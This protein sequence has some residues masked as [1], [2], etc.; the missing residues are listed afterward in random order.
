M[1]SLTLA[2]PVCS[3]GRVWKEEKGVSA[4]DDDGDQGIAAWLAY[5]H[6]FPLSAPTTTTST[7][8]IGLVVLSTSLSTVLSFFPNL[9]P[10]L[11]SRARTTST[12]TKKSA[13]DLSVQDEFGRISS[14]G[15]ARQAVQQHLV[16]AK[17]A[18]K[19]DGKGTA[20]GRSSTGD[21]DQQE[22]VPP[23]ATFLPLSL[24][25]RGTNPTTSRGRN[26]ILPTTMGIFRTV[27]MS[28]W[29]SKSGE[30]ADTDIPEHLHE[31]VVGA[32][33]QWRRRIVRGTKPSYSNCRTQATPSTP[34]PVAFE[35]YASGPK[36]TLSTEA[37]QDRE[38]AIREALA[39]LAKLGFAGLTETDLGKLNKADEYEEELQLMA[40]VRAYFQVAYKVRVIDYVPL[41]ID[42][43]FLYA[44]AAALHERLFERLGLGAANAQARCSAYIAE[45]PTVVATRDELVAKKKRLENVRRA[46]YNFGL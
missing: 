12:P 27:D 46:L 28:S 3:E 44:F 36:H 41:T 31:A 7:T 39:A 37:Q 14:R 34:A 13:F 5:R 32:D 26:P 40:E 23:D 43:H 6:Q 29:V 24:E 8:T 42:H 38:E 18:G 9:M 1:L 2:S 10:S 35:R 45:D 30:E 11:F 19:K 16:T 17:K 21:D 4:V 15:S 20:K 22:Y 33:R 25:S